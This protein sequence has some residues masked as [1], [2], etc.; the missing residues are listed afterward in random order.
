MKTM[1]SGRSLADVLQA[2]RDHTCKPRAKLHANNSYSQTLKAQDLMHLFLF[3]SS[4]SRLI[5]ISTFSFDILTTSFC[6]VT[7]L[8]YL[9]KVPGYWTNSFI[10][11]ANNSY[12]NAVRVVLNTVKMRTKSFQ[13]KK[14]FL[15][16]LIIFIV[17]LFF[18]RNFMC[19]ISLINSQ[20]TKKQLSAYSHLFVISFYFPRHFLYA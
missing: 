20:I 2:L 17:S 8:I 7:L 16:F 19:Y 18:V 14:D 10:P 15:L 3:S 9:F 6:F 12:K 4:F 13:L 5:F 1:K 11:H